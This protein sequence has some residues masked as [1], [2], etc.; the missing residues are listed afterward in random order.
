MSASSTPALGDR[1]PRKLGPLDAA[2]LVISNVIGVGIFTTPGFVAQLVPH[3][4]MMLGLW[5]L[6][7]VLAFVGASAYSELAVLRP[8]AGGEYVYLREAF[9]S[10]PAFLSGWTSFVAGF[11]GAIAAGAVGLAAYLSHYVPLA[12]DTRPL[13]SVSLFFTTLEISTRSIVALICIAL[14]SAVH[15]RGLA[16]GRIVQNTLAGLQVS[17]LLILVVL[18]FSLGH[19]SKAHFAVLPGAVKPVTLLLALVPVMFTYSGWNA[20]AYVAEEVRDPC[21]NLPRALALGTF[22]VIALYLLLNSVYIY[23]APTSELA[24]SI[25]TGELAARALLG[26]PAARVIMP[27]IIVA[28][29]GAISAMMLAGPRVYFAMARD[30]VFPTRAGK[31]HRRYLTPATA[32]LAQALW[33]GILVISGTFEQILLFTGFAVVLF[34]GI[35]VVSLFVLRWKL[36]DEVRSVRAWGFPW[37]PGV[38]VAVSLAMVVNAFREQPRP[39]AAGALVIAAGLPV[40]WWFVRRGHRSDCAG[41]Q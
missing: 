26:E 19:G 36:R 5:L 25:N 20:A 24:S 30:G 4:L 6:G 35:A 40:Y 8:Q 31:V 15:I 3:P 18:G 13:L 10:L 9:G 16:P 12:G 22:T 2:A 38:F 17:A 34:S 11:S 14:L 41:G 39:S 7:G 29:A 23:A 27:V 37:L 28:L 1:L 32:I 33:S 21:R